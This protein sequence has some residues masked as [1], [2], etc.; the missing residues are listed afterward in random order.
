MLKKVLIITGFIALSTTLSSCTYVNASLGKFRGNKSAE[1]AEPI[2]EDNQ[3]EPEV[4]AAPVEEIIHNNS[5]KHNH[6]H[7]HREGV[8]TVSEDGL[9]EITC[10]ETTY[11]S[12]ANRIQTLGYIPADS[13]LP[14]LKANYTPVV[15]KKAHPKPKV[16]KKPKPTKVD[17]YNAPKAKATEA[18]VT[19]PV[20]EETIQV[21]PATVS[22]EEKPATPVAPT[23]APKTV[24]QP[25][26]APHN[27]APAPMAVPAPTVAPTVP[28]V[29]VAPIAPI[30]PTTV[31]AVPVAPTAPV[32][33]TS[34][35]ASAVN[36]PE[37][38]TKSAADISSS[39]SPHNVVANQ[40]QPTA[41]PMSSEQAHPTNAT[42]SVGRLATLD[43]T[44]SQVDI[45]ATGTSTL[46]QIADDLK[47]NP[48]KNVKIQSYA[49]S[50]DGN[51][52]EARRNSLQRAIKVRKYLI[53]K[54][55]NASRISVNAIE[56]INNKLNKVE[57]SFEESKQ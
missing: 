44:E 26:Q 45:P 38:A 55:V 17:S 15:H 36:T 46:D 47:R 13:C 39:A 11:T 43:Y 22:A 1:C 57:I 27:A 14:E 51:A 31:P 33:P 54:D 32:A 8:I 52:T 9:K 49:F 21:A 16:K 4:R 18:A 40:Q 20:I 19:A 6:V 35:S 10:T 3:V 53:D 37:L 12:T 50:K 56:D 34:S 29:P 48:G 42:V 28:A 25:M 2:C 5:H 30:A 24:H 41:S 23:E 7:M